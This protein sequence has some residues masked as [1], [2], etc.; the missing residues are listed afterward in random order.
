LHAPERKAVCSNTKR[1]RES[2]NISQ[3]QLDA[4]DGIDKKRCFLYAKIIKNIM[5]L[6]KNTLFKQILGTLFVGSLF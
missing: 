1:L 2:S 4:S 6:Y 3:A 5:S